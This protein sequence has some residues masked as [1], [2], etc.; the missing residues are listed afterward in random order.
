MHTSFIHS[1][2]PD[3]FNLLDFIL[4]VVAEVVV[5][6]VADVVVVEV[7][8]VVVAV[9]SNGTPVVVDSVLGIVVAID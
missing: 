8:V 2:Q 5:V 3:L 4:L 7:D 9:I 1:R 6:V